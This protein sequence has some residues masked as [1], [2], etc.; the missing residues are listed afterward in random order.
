MSWRKRTGTVESE[1]S[2][3]RGRKV[4]GPANNPRHARSN[5][6][7]HLAGRFARGHALIARRK[8]REIAIPAGRELT[9]QLAVD[10]RRCIGMLAPVGRKPVVPFLAQRRAALAKAVAQTVI[11]AFGHQ[12]LRILRPAVETLCETDL[13][14]AQRVAVSRRRV[15]LMRGAV[16][17][18]A[19]EN[20]E[21]RCAP[22]RSHPALA[23]R[24]SG[25]PRNGSP[26]PR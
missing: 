24:S 7:E 15:L 26:H 25:N 16:T 13:L 23:A 19:V 8:F 14:L 22:D 3:G 5:R 12:K 6:V 9:T 11:D 18:G 17:D 21:S 10:L 1:F 2:L 20:D 4:S